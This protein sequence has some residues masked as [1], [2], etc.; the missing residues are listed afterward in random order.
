MTAEMM[1][2]PTTTTRLVNANMN[3]VSWFPRLLFRGCT[4]RMKSPI[5]AW[6]LEPSQPGV[7]TCPSKLLFPSGSS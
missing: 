2:P 3:R 4:A 1:P 7:S 5:S 6:G